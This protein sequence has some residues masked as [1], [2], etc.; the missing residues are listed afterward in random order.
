MIWNKNNVWDY[1]EEMA[2]GRRTKAQLREQAERQK[3][4][5]EEFFEKEDEDNNYDQPLLGNFDQQQENEGEG[6]VIGRDFGKRI[7][8]IARKNWA[9]K[10]EDEPR[11]KEEGEE[12]KKKV[13]VEIIEGYMREEG[14]GDKFVIYDKPLKYNY[15]TKFKD[16][17]KV[18]IVIPKEGKPKKRKKRKTK[19]LKSKW[20]G[21]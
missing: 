18:Y 4:L 20:K 17:I 13:P 1:E 12:R 7:E 15:K 10:W 5:L 19:K 2:E 6:I 8:E 9:R 14:E 16:M 11:G 3:S 21:I